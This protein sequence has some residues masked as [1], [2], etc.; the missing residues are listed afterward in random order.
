ME[1]LDHLL[2]DQVEAE[3]KFLKQ[4]T[5]PN[6]RLKHKEWNQFFRYSTDEPRRQIKKALQPKSV[7]NESVDY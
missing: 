1:R 3:T 5:A 6:I 7:V 2:A 4:T